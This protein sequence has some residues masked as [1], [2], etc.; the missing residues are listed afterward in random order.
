[1]SFYME[2][3]ESNVI[4]LPIIVGDEVKN[5]TIQIL[6]CNDNSKYLRLNEVEGY[7]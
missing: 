7:A 4:N 5:V 3:I 6:E 2:Y 1:M